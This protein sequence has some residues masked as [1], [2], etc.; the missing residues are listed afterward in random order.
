VPHPGTPGSTA[1]RREPA[2]QTNQPKTGTA[3]SVTSLARPLNHR[4][5]ERRHPRARLPRPDHIPVGEPDR[6]RGPDRGKQ[7]RQRKLQPP[8]QARSAPGILLPQPAQ[9]AATRPDR[10]HP[11]SPP[12]PGPG[13]HRDQDPDTNR[14]RPEPRTRLT[15]KAPSSARW[16]T[17]TAVAP[18]MHSDSSD[19]IPAWCAVI[20]RCTTKRHKSECP[21]GL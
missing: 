20:G 12:A 4:G 6:L 14:N 17:R 2:N 3:R 16:R 11:G 1:T 9:P 15:A 5:P 7:R 21:P 13:T 18:T 8:G 10:L 19:G